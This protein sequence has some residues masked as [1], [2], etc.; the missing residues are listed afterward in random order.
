MNKLFFFT[1]HQ[2]HF[3]SSLKIKIVLFFS[4]KIRIIF[5]FKKSQAPTP[6]EV[7]WSAPFFSGT[8]VRVRVCSFKQ[9]IQWFSL[10]MSVNK[11]V[12]ISLYHLLLYQVLQ[13]V[14]TWYWNYTLAAALQC[15]VFLSALYFNAFWVN[16]ADYQLP[17]TSVSLLLSITNKKVLVHV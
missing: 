2:K 1:R 9:F 16:V 13:M 3:F 6:Q 7:K 17:I 15:L 10:L 14:L 8:S 5:V 4:M 11:Q 12:L